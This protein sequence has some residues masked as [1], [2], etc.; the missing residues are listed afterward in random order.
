[1]VELPFDEKDPPLFLELLNFTDIDPQNPK[2]DIVLTLN[3]K[4]ASYVDMLSD[5]DVA[6]IKW[7]LP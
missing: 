4:V 6:V 3:G 2:G 5:G 1:M 7:A